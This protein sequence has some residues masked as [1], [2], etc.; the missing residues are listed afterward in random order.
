MTQKWNYLDNLEYQQKVIKST[1]SLFDELELERIKENWFQNNSIFNGKPNPFISKVDWENLVFPKLQE[2][3]KE[4]YI[5]NQE[6]IL[7][8]YN[9]KF[10]IFDIE[11]ETG[12]GKTYIFLRTIHELYKKNFS[13][14]IILV[15][16]IAIEEGVCKAI[17]TTSEHFDKLYN[18]QGINLFK[19]NG[20]QS[21]IN[22][23][24][25]DSSLSVLIMNISQI[26]KSVNI[27]NQELENWNNQKIIDL[28]KLVNPIVIIDE[29]QSTA[30][31]IKSTEAIKNLNPNFILRYSATFKKNDKLSG[32]LIYKL[33]PIDAYNENLVKQITCSTINDEDEKSNQYIKLEELDSSKQTCRLKLNIN[34]KFKSF[35]CKANDNLYLKT[36]NKN[37]EG[38]IIDEN[39]ISFK[40]SDRYVLF[41]NGV[42]IYFNTSNEDDSKIKI[43]QIHETLKKHLDKQISLLNN[44]VKVLSLFF[45][46][47]VDDYRVFN[48]N[49][50]HKLGKYGEIFEKELTKILVQDQKDGNKYS[51]ILNGKTIDE[52][53]SNCHGGYFAKDSKAG[54]QKE[55]Y[56]LIMKDKEKLLSFSSN[57]SF[58][59]T[60]S[61]LQEGWDNPNV[62]Q[63]CFLRNKGSSENRLRQQIGRG[64][65]LCVNDKLERV[66]DK[67]INEL[68]IFV[69]NS[70]EEFIN[71]YQTELKEDGVLLNQISVKRLVEEIG[72]SDYQAEILINEFKKSHILDSNNLIKIS[73]DEFKNDI[74]KIIL[75]NVEF[76]FLNDKE[77][78]L[79]NLLFRKK[80]IE[81]YIRNSKKR[82][83][84]KLNEDIFNNLYFLQIWKIISSKTKYKVAFDTKEL[85]SDIIKNFEAKSVEIQNPKLI[86]EEYKL[87]MNPKI[88][89]ESKNNYSLRTNHQYEQEI[90]SKE[91]NEFIYDIVEE[92]KLTRRT[93]I[94][95][96]SN[97]FLKQKIKINLFKTK[98]LLFECI[99]NSLNELMRRGIEYKKNNE[100]WQQEI[101]DKEIIIYDDNIYDVKNKEKSLYDKIKL[102]SNVEKEF[103]GECDDCEQVKLFIKLPKKFFIKT[104]IGNYSP[105]WALNIKDGQW[106][107]VVETKANISENDL[108]INESYKIKCGEKHFKAISRD[109]GG[110]FKYKACKNL[111]EILNEC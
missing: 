76:N 8:L 79:F 99:K 71:Q 7:Y 88:G 59:F 110:K 98:A 102:D 62:F 17:Q 35:T 96:L 43:L 30:S 52:F 82:T 47:A 68:T 64:L 55:I 29:P 34:G 100:F 44:N 58:I 51:K 84:S 81:K 49:S 78:E 103:V 1:I 45:L 14:F 104:P 109:I 69:N 2:I 38:Y 11:M 89:L 67:N 73:A 48:E 15:P 74:K 12:T 23:F 108:R 90:T 5:V 53:V 25:S 32:N 20:Q 72:L 107:F 60:H 10:P 50:N 70:Y 26:N 31:G 77:D 105:D 39:G 42:K 61:A 41:T 21:N 18:N 111:G 92:T 65:R 22:N 93:I 95:I 46:D 40:E 4:N 86:S 75:S 13:K 63:I 3:Q 54:S 37:Y 94:E 80:E 101:F 87:K 56:N 91:I 106:V 9:D 24:L 66:I 6:K 97:D 83:V 16:S 28:I 57:L 36:N 33:G 85:I 27:I 19:F